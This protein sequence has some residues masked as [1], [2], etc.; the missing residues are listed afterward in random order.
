MHDFARVPW[1]KILSYDADVTM[2]ADARGR[3]KTF[4]MREQF[5]RDALAKQSTFV[6]IVRHE[7]RIKQVANGYFDALAKPNAEG[8]ATS[9]VFRGH[10]FI[11]RRQ[12]RDMLW[13][14]VPPE[15][16]EDPKY[17]P[18]PKKWE[19]IGY[20][21]SLS[22]AQD[23]KEMTFARV[24]RLCLD[25]ALIQNPNGRHNYL[26]MEFEQLISIVDSCTR[27]QPGDS[28]HKPNVYLLSNAC[29]IV[30]P[31]FQHYGITS[32]PPDGFSWWGGKT[33]LLFVGSDAGYSE[34]KATQTVAGRMS[35]NTATAAMANDNRFVSARLGLVQGKTPAARFQYGLACNGCKYG[36]WLD[37]AEGLYYVNEQVPNGATPIYALTTADNALNYVMARRSQPVMQSLIEMYS[38]GLVRFSTPAVRERCETEVFRLYGLR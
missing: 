21:V 10:H 19:R 11:F 36:V 25:E 8:Q 3:G 27:E 2:V 30:N 22:K 37:L 18:D 15:R 32:I 16:L 6:Q 38:L 23:Y 20:F 24:R 5:V 35:A 1:R 26:P 12:S 14:D 28:R 13:Q 34:A 9:E 7:S 17:K 31:Y 4:G 33:F 29:S